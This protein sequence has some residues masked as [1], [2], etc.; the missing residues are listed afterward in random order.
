VLADPLADVA[1]GTFT[2]A[3]LAAG[4]PIDVERLNV[5]LL[6]VRPAN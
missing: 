6:V 3:E 1:L 5:R 4:I 2:Q